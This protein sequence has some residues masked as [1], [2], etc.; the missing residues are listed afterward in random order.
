MRPTVRGG[1]ARFDDRLRRCQALLD[2]PGPASRLEPLTALAA[3]LTHQRQRTSDDAVRAASRSLVDTARARASAGI[4]PMFDGGAA[5]ATIDAELCR[6]VD[7]LALGPVPRPL[8][9]AGLALVGQPRDERQLAIEDWV[10]DA[11]AV[12]AA[13]AFWIRV[14]AAPVFEGAAATLDVP[15]PDDWRSA[16]CPVCGAAAQVATITEESGEFMGGS[17][18]ALV[19]SRCASSWPHPRITCALCGEQDPRQI[20][21]FLAGDDRVARVDTCLRCHGYIKTFD[22]RSAGANGVV[23]LVDDVATLRLDVWASQRGFSRPSLSLAG[24]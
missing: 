23:P 20:N 18:R 9:D 11:D 10:D 16:A 15:I 17:P 22:L 13:H 3:V 14:A 21:A 24:V 19:C 4:F 2:Q 7:V 8:V 5:V 6:A 12:E 1:P